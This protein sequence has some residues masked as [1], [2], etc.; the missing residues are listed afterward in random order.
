V[1]LVSQREDDDDDDD[2]E[3]VSSSRT[4]KPYLR[5]E[6]QNPLLP[7]KQWPRPPAARRPIRRRTSRQRCIMGNT[8]YGHV[9]TNMQHLVR[10]NIIYGPLSH[11]RKL[12]CHSQSP[13]RR[14]MRR[15][16]RART[17]PPSVTISQ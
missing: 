3:G 1:F 16:Q 11:D 4:W 13:L 12:S 9:G 8:S 2:D 17:R 5:A 15:Q 14:P 7:V 10:V 6:P